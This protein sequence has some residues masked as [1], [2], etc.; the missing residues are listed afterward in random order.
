[1]KV[2]QRRAIV[3]E[4]CKVSHARDQFLIYIY[5]ILI[6]NTHLYLKNIKYNL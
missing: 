1:M 6:L 3:H 2:R 5:I 4:S